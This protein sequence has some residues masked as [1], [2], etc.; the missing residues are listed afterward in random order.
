MIHR[1][2]K[3]LRVA[4]CLGDI[5]GAISR[6]GGYI[7]LMSEEAFLNDMKTQDAVIKNLIDVGEASNN[8]MQIDPALKQMRPELWQH[9]LGA[10]EM[11]IKLT[12]G[13]RS[14]DAGIVW[15]TA[16]LY[17]PEF[18]R[19]VEIALSEIRSSDQGIQ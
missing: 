4:D 12:H 18:F 16:N 9:L 10:Y 5:Q 11:R 7:D 2:G 6:I 3:I 19:V 17:L 8:A 15:A 1:P 13:Y 14:V